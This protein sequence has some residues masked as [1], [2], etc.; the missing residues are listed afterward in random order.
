[1]SYR[2]KKRRRR[3]LDASCSVREAGVWFHLCDILEQE[4]SGD[5]KI[6]GL[7]EVWRVGEKGEW[8]EHGIFTTMK[9][10]SRIL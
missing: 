9:L 7:L 4:H 3:N 8:V 10:I 6:G 2:A 1:M 5:E